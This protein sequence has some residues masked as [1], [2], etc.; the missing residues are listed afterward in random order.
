MYKLFS[1]FLR[2]GGRGVCITALLAL[3]PPGPVLAKTPDLSRQAATQQPLPPLKPV[4]DAET[5]YPKDY[6]GELRRHKVAYEDTLMKLAIRHGVGFV[7]LRAANP[8]VDEWL[9]GEGMEILLPRRHI[10]PD[11]PRDGVV[12]NL[13]EMRV[14]AYLHAGKA[15]L[16]FPIGI[17]KEGTDTPLGSTI[18]RAKRA[19]PVWRPTERMQRENP[20]LPDIVPAGDNNPL[21][22]HALYLGWPTYLI[23]GTDKPW[24]IGR[25]IS[26]GCIRLYPGDIKTFF[27]EVPVGARVT[28]VNQPVKLG[29]IDGNLYMEAHPGVEQSGY[30]EKHGVSP[31]PEPVPG[32]Y[33]RLLR[34]ADGPG[35]PGMKLDWPKIRQTL[36]E[37]R[38]IP[39]KIA[40][41]HTET[42]LAG[43]SE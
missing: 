12:V 17:G 39:V 35:Q 42:E 11:A 29:R 8:G 7:E 28:V 38:G 20:D 24:G 6:I 31:P 22:S 2:L 26:S 15:P 1:S 3:G 25:R 10:L 37:R 40:T 13:A 43:R 30:V 34:A 5:R 16:T 27:Q 19:A 9:P 36:Y 21:G 33:S 14:Y 41:P 18:V 23:H 32:L 4:T